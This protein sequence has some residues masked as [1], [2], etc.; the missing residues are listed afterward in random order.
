M[1]MNLIGPF[2]K[3]ETLVIKTNFCDIFARLYGEQPTT[4]YYLSISDWKNYV[5]AKSN[6]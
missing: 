5:S 6:K 2:Q 4:A 1:K 3:C